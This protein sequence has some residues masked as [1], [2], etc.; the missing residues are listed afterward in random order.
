MVD[1]TPLRRVG[2][3]RAVGRS[4]RTKQ[5]AHPRS[6]IELAARWTRR[7]RGGPDLPRASH[8]RRCSSP[9]SQPSQRWIKFRPSVESRSKSK[10]ENRLFAG[11]TY[12]VGGEEH[13]IHCNLNLYLI[14]WDSVFVHMGVQTP[15]QES[16]VSMAPHTQWVSPRRLWLYV[17]E[18]APPHPPIQKQMGK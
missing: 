8:E 5:G 3:V 9:P 4:G 1:T 14:E 7:S 12:E 17:M 6:R 16:C 11:G 10:Y 13:W 15:S 2:G 18:K